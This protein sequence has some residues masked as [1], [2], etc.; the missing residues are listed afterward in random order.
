M[1]GSTVDPVGTAPTI[2]LNLEHLTLNDGSKVFPCKN[3]KDFH[4]TG[5]SLTPEWKQG[6]IKSLVFENH[7]YESFVSQEK[8]TMTCPETNLHFVASKN[9]A[10]VIKL[11]CF[12]V[13]Q[14]REGLSVVREIDIFQQF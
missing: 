10:N 3:T 11:F 1:T 14:D 12:R 6:E 5:L 7:K 13:T 4:C 9:E 8:V 2:H